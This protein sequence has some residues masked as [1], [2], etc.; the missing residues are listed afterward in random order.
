MVKEAEKYLQLLDRTYY[1]CLGKVAKVVGLTIESIGPEARLNDLCRIYLDETRQ[2]FVM[3]EVVGFRDSRLILM[4][5]DNVEGVGVGCV[6]DNTGH[7][8]SVL[9][10]EDL[11]GHTVDGIGR[12][13]DGKEEKL[14]NSYP[15]EAMP[16]DPMEREIIS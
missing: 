12:I 2:N 3:A 6:V 4:P 11:L 16:P 14:D 7:P 15:V 8:L 5:Y 9:V 10:G 1:K 13:T